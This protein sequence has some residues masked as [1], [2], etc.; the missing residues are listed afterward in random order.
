[1]YD[2]LNYNALFRGECAEAEPSVFNPLL[3]AF[4]YVTT[5]A[6]SAT[7]KRAS[8]YA[9]ISLNILLLLA[10]DNQTFEMLCTQQANVH[11]CKQVRITVHRI[12]QV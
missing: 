10:E 6:W 3:S 11:I 4:T 12:I 9:R 1:M 7:S 2:L 8:T 5:N